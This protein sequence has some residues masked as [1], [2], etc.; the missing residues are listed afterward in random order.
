MKINVLITGADG[1]LGRHLLKSLSSA[2]IYNLIPFFFKEEPMVTKNGWEGNLTNY[3]H[4]RYFLKKAPHPD[5]IIH[6]AGTI[7]IDF[8]STSS[9]STIFPGKTP[10]HELYNNNTLAVA[11]LLDFSLAAGTKHIFF[12]SSQTVYGAPLTPNV[13][14]NSPCL[15]LEHYAQSKVFGEQILRLGIKQNIKVT[16]LRFPGL[17][18]EQR[19]SG[20]VHTFCREA[21][22]KNKISLSS[23]ISIPFDFIHINE[24]VAFI[25]MYLNQVVQKQFVSQAY[26][27]FNVSYGDFCS[28]TLL[29]EEI[30]KILPA[31][32]ILRECFEQQP[33]RLENFKAT[34]LGWNPKTR[35][36][37][38]L[39]LIKEYDQ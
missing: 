1:F 37:C 4:L 34:S 39:S 17:V 25:Q 6:L 7:N 10:C 3:S 12:A 35:A 13:S 24:V 30:K 22:T 14:E 31:T 27:V 23:N 36:E 9:G 15:P 32:Q 8:A 18:S 16:I 21:L 38:L 11:N 20:I 26:E 5:I 19:H 33:I 29:A 28:L 2:L